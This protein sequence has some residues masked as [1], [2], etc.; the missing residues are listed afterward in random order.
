MLLSAGSETSQKIS[1]SDTFGPPEICYCE[2]KT[3]LIPNRNERRPNQD[4]IISSES[5]QSV[6]H[7]EGGYSA[8]MRMYRGY[9]QLEGLEYEWFV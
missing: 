3:A 6:L 7:G 1:K 8:A 5:N 2:K 4:E 9:N